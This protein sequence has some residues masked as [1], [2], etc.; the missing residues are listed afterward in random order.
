MSV[1]NKIMQVFNQY[2]KPRLK[3]GGISV[4]SFRNGTLYLNIHHKITDRNLLQ[5][6]NDIFHNLVEEIVDIKRS[7]YSDLVP[8]IEEEMP[9]IGI[10]LESLDDDWK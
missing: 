4:E 6:I 3:K 8:P 1:D 9:Y 5:G 10:E 2:V 7:D